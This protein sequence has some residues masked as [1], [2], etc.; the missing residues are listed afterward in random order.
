MI[1]EMI[2]SNT[3]WLICVDEVHQFVSFGLSFRYEFKQVKDVLFNKVIHSKETK[4]EKAVLKVPV[5]FMTATFN[6]ELLLNLSKLTGLSVYDPTHAW[7]PVEDFKKRNIDLH[8][9]TTP[10]YIKVLKN[11]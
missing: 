7:S 9:V 5:L 10:Q 2:K 3:I 1:E 6:Q 8:L 11:N 4:T